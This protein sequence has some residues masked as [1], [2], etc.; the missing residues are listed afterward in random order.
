[1]QRRLISDQMDKATILSDATKYVKELHGKLKD[2][3]AG[4]SNRR[5]S[6]E[7]VVLVK[8]PC[9][10]AAPAPDDDDSPLS[11]SS[12]SGTPAETKTQ[13]PEIEARFAENSVM[14][15]IHCEDGKGVAVKVLAEVEELHLSII[16]AN[17]LPFVEGT[18]I[19]TIT[20][21]ASFFFTDQ[22]FSKKKELVLVY[23]TAHS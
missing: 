16:H 18:L 22:S 4:G 14:V 11:A 20:A 19:I 23:S 12:G 21:K 6:I 1:M 2:L 5:K 8:R 7:T 15:R 3:E 9:L 10:H 17:V 13:L